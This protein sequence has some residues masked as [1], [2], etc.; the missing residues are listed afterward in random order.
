MVPGTLEKILHE[1][2]SLSAEDK[3]RLADQ[4]YSQVGISREIE[5]EWRFE[6]D[7][8]SALSTSGKMGSITLAEFRAKYGERINRHSERPI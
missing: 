6:L 2:E 3:T 8:R 7:R 1:T 4:L 5:N